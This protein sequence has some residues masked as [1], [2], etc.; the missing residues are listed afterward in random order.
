MATG[1]AILVTIQGEV[2]MVT[3]PVAMVIGRVAMVTGDLHH[4]T[5]LRSRDT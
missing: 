5:K 1:G 2:A 3:V 4:V